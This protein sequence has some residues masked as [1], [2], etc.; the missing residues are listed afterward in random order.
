MFGRGWQT[1]NRYDWSCNCDLK[2]S[3]EE[4][5]LDQYRCRSAWSEAGANALACWYITSGAAGV[6]GRRDDAQLHPAL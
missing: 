3:G 1:Q 2:H 4:S 6:H 5:G